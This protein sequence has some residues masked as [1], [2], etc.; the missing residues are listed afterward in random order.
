[1]MRETLAWVDYS[2]DW[3]DKASHVSNS[4]VTN[5]FRMR[6]SARLL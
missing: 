4:N 3:L 6:S 2:R 1:M 5:P